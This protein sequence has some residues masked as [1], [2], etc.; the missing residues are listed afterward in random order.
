L[1]LSLTGVLSVKAR[2]Q[3]LGSR[4]FDVTLHARASQASA[5]AEQAAWLSVSL[6]LDAL[7]LPRR[8]VPASSLPAPVVDAA[9]P[10]P[11]E[12]T[13][14]TSPEPSRDAVPPVSFEQLRALSE[15][16]SR[17]IAFALG[18]IGAA[19]ERRRLDA[20]SSRARASAALPE[21]R[22]RA[23]RSTDQALRWVPTNDDPYRITQADGAGLTLEASVT[24]HLDR[25]LF[26]AEE[27]VVERLR[28]RVASE[29]RKLELRVLTAVLGLFRARQLA[30]AEGPDA[31]PRSQHLLRLLELFAELDTLTAGWFARE[32]PG[33]SSAIWGF[34]E[35]VLGVCTAPRRARR[36]PPAQ[37]DTKSV[38][39][40]E[41]SE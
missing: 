1:A 4:R 22:L 15:L 14:S 33:F 12:P 38:A 17:A 8:A 7:A 24:F 2:A 11:D 25:L 13:D 36:E 18:A 20:L 28:V 19:A 40:L 32:A 39:S 3:E 6:P 34:P 41:D 30:C 23:Q 21:L 31:P 35:A 5:R 37:S 29:H 16:S 26:S 9:A 27:L 10:V